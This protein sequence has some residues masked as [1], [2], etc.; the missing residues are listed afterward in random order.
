MFLDGNT[1]KLLNQPDKLVVH[2]VVGVAIRLLIWP[3]QAGKT[4]IIG[5]GTAFALLDVKPTTRLTT[6]LYCSME[7][8]NC[9]RHNYQNNQ[10]TWNTVRQAGWKSL[11]LSWTTRLPRIE[12]GHTRAESD[13]WMVDSAFSLCLFKWIAGCGCTVWSTKKST[14]LLRQCTCAWPNARSQWQA[15]CVRG[16]SWLTTSS[17]T[18]IVRLETWHFH[19]ENTFPMV[20]GQLPEGSGHVPVYIEI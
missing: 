13:P 20:I 6:D 18:F 12:G 10:L 11:Q 4:Y 17:S 19:H 1:D 16:L 5:C 9:G 8:F 3:T 15:N 7:H 14:D 2:F